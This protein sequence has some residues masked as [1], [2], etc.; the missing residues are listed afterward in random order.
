MAFLANAAYETEGTTLAERIARE[1]WALL[2]QELITASN[3]GLEESD[4]ISGYFV[5]NLTVTPRYESQA[6]AFVARQDDTLSLVFQGSANG[7][8]KTDAVL[9]QGRYYSLFSDLLAAVEEYVDNPANGITTVYVTGHSLGGAMTEVYL[10]NDAANL[11]NITL[12]G[13]VFGSVGTDQPGTRAPDE[14]VSVRHTGDRPVALAEFS[15]PNLTRYGQA[16]DVDLP[17]VPGGNAEHRMVLYEKNVLAIVGSTLFEETRTSDV[18]TVG[19]SPQNDTINL[20]QTQSANFILGLA[21]RD[22]ITGGLQRDLID[23]GE[24]RDTISGGS[25]DDLIYGGNEQDTMRSGDLTDR[26]TFLFISHIDSPITRPDLIEDFHAD[27]LT[28]DVLDLRNTGL[29]TYVGTGLMVAGNGLAE[30]RFNEN[31]STLVGDI[32]DDGRG[33]FAV[34]VPGTA[35][36]S[37]VVGANLL[38]ADPPDMG[39]VVRQPGPADGVDVWITNV[40]DWGSDFGVDDNTLRVG[41]W[42]DTYYSLIQFDLA[43]LPQ[44]AASAKIE[45]YHDLAWL[46][47]DNRIAPEMQL[48]R[49]DGPWDESLGWYTPQPEAT[50]LANLPAAGDGWYEIDITDLYNQWQAGTVANHGIE[51]RPVTTTQNSTRFLS[52]DYLENESLRPKLVVV[53]EGAPA[54][55]L[56]LSAAGAG[57]AHED[58]SMLAA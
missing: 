51:L 52:S 19:R 12:Q 46:Q 58:W 41:G 55:S 7:R 56:A 48:F 36:A 32:D 28:G 53:E 3:D 27:G 40:L 30:I 57:A 34:R 6:D 9:H 20:A 26:D 29:D 15:N 44:A 50:Y 45:L 47:A 13:A 22:T 33:D 24:G 54:T 2:N 39:P 21:G 35:A 4:F 38:L 42:N 23:G 10:R 25:G 5:E 14:L 1:G 16:V 17:N 43:G 18:V 49:V 11:D 31:V 37:F 8:D